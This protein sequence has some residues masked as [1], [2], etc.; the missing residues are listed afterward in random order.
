MNNIIIFGILLFVF[1]ILGGVFLSEKNTSANLSPA[2][3]S[4]SIQPASH[5]QVGEEHPPYNSNP[6]SSGWHWSKEADWGVYEQKLPDEQVVHNLEHGGVNIFY[7]P[8]A[9]REIIEKLKELV[10]P[11]PNRTILAPR[12]KNNTLIALVS[13]GYV[14]KMSFL[15]EE[16]IK[17][18]LKNNR[19]R[20][21]EKLPD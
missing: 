8:E 14:L 15:D 10:R 20:G 3:E 21:P 18:F 12:S 2:G 7:Q 19:N 4:F 9:H 17:E 1:I 16:K 6:P 13:W 11:Y 5:I